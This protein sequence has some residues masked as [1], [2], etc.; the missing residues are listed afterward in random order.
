MDKL[1]SCSNN[2][3]RT[4]LK[5]FKFKS[6]ILIIALLSCKV[7]ANLT[8]NWK[9][10]IFLRNFHHTLSKESLLHVSNKCQIIATNLLLK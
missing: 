7:M 9:V 10:A 2:K 4:T 3:S 1:L 5:D 8:V 6:K